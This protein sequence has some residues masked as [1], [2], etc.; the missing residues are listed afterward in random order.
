MVWL[1]IDRT[2]SGQAVYSIG[3]GDRPPAA[4]DE[5]LTLPQVLERLDAR[6]KQSALGLPVRIAGHKR[7]PFGAVKSLTA[8]LERRKRPGGVTEIKAEVNEKSS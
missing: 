5:K 2:E 7:L 4:D 1:G 8:E 6:L 3:Q